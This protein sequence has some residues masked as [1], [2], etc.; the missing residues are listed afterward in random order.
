MELL[1][2]YLIEKYVVLN[3]VLAQREVEYNIESV[4][5][6]VELAGV[7]YLLGLWTGHLSLRP[8]CILTA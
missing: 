7:Y 8:W 6:C 1:L 2:L 4:S 5:G 3:V